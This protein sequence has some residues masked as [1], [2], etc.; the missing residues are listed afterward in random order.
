MRPTKLIMS[1]FGPYAERT[2]I[3]LNRLGKCGIYLITGDTGAGKTTIF[4]AITFALFGEASG[5]H[6]NPGMM[7]SKYAGQDIPTEVELTFEYQDKEYYIKRN[8][9]Y[10]R[11]KSRGEGITV[12]KPGVMLKMPN[13]S[14]I[15]KTSEVNEKI[16]QILGVDRNQFSRICMIAQGDFL[17]LLFSSTEERKKIF[18]KLFSTEKYYYLQENLKR[19]SAR[20]GREYDEIAASIRQYMEGI[21]VDPD[22]D[23]AEE[24][25]MARAGEIPADQAIELTGKLV[26][27]DEEILGKIKQEERETEHE[28]NKIKEQL[29]EAKGFEEL[30]KSLEQAEKDLKEKTP[31]LESARER[32]EKEK[33][34]AYEAEKLLSRIA[35]ISSRL[36]EY[37]KLEKEGIRIGKINEELLKTEKLAADKDST[38]NKLEEEIEGLKLERIS[39]ADVLFI[40]AD[41]EAKKKEA[42]AELDEAEKLDADLQDIK[43]RQK[44]LSAAQ[45]EYLRSSETA[46]AASERYEMLNKAYLDEQAGI[47]AGTLVDGEPCPVCGSLDH[48]KKARLS[49]CAPSREELEIAKKY[50]EEKST[51]KENLSRKAAE[52]RAG[53][54]EKTETVRKKT[55]EL[56]NISDPGEADKKL[57]LKKQ[58]LKEKADDIEKELDAVNKRSERKKMLENV[59]PQR[60]RALADINGELEKLRVKTAELKST[61]ANLEKSCREF[62]SRLQYSSR[63]EAEAVI[64]SLNGARENINASIEKAVQDYNS[65]NNEIIRLTSIISENRKNLTGRVKPDVESE[66]EKQQALTEKREKLGGMLT[67]IS[68]RIAGNRE[69]YDNLT[70]KYKEAAE[71]EKKWQQVR[72]LSDTAN[73]NLKGK[74]KIMLETYIQMRFFDRIIARANQRML[75]MTGGQYELKRAGQAASNKSQSGLDLDVVD[76]NNGSLRSVRTL[77]GGEAFK[78]SLSLALGLSDEIQSGAGGIRLDTMFVDEGFGSLDE[79]SLRQAITALADLSDGN[80]LVGIISHVSELKDRIDKQIVVTRNGPEGSKV[81]LEI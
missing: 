66:K 55:E 16:V 18:Q 44:G 67:D 70:G 17:K 38:R 71:T 6:K 33:K 45:E 57:A 27:R 23:L 79:E 64:S 4:D 78:A 14:T 53:L 2:E 31:E 52:I 26:N 58:E 21:K 75:I 76:H 35:E 51:E 41:L 73:G 12:E 61:K 36:P 25:M 40:K 37:E 59:F 48:P 72:S 20:L 77:S 29:A 13:G 3:D 62:A 9:E 60:E 69:I 63:E 1:A 49:V 8:P 22:S 28:L 7:R 54:E 47:I 5:E 68:V 30:A 74:E 46:H 24:A 19:I 43:N 80:R 56:L 81:R 42:S 32:M 15:T 10:E 65:C 34:R 39:L 50:S 11:P